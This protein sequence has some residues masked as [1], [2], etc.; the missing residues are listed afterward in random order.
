[1]PALRAGR[2]L[3]RAQAIV[4]HQF[5]QPGERGLVRQPLEGQPRGR[6]GRVAVIGQQVAPAEF[7]RVHTQ[8]AR[9]EIDQPLRHHAGHGVAH[10]AVLAGGR[11]VGEGHA[12]PR[13]IGRHAV[14]GAG[15]VHHLVALDRTGPRIDGIGPDAGEII[16]R[17]C[18]D[19][20]I[21]RDRQLAIDGVFARVN[22]GG[23]GFQPVRHEFHRSAQQL[24]DRHGRHV[25]GID[26]HLDAEGPPHI[27]A[28]DAHAL[29]GQAEMLGENLL[30][31]VRR[32]AGV[33]H[34]QQAGRAVPVG[35]DGARLQRH[36]GVARRREPRL[37]HEMRRGEGGI[38]IAGVHRAREGEVV[39]QV[40]MDGR[41][42][43]RGLRVGHCG[44]RFP[45]GLDQGGGVF[46]L[47]AALRH[48]GGHGLAL[49]DGAAIG[50]RRL[51]R[52]FQALEMRQHA[53]PRRHHRGEVN[54]RQHRHH[55]GHGGSGGD[56]EREARMRVGAAQIGH[57]NQPRQP[58]II[59]IA[60]ATGDQPRRR[61]AR[62]GAADPGIGAIRRAED[63]VRHGGAPARSRATLSMASTMAW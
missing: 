32:L 16:D 58:Q 30:H 45:F 36:A 40:G 18:E 51:R 63:T 19:G 1:M 20:A 13:P 29:L 53:D 15:D 39:P 46:C 4:I 38:H 44:Q 26:M 25:I 62:A 59:H 3:L 54:R 47:G 27:G 2:H 52:R 9:R 7:G 55:A 8:A 60:P 57:V 48:H 34:R 31:H 17:E 10:G 43:E 14:P 12:Q 50:Q 23:E 33:M 37:H 35:Q 28:D 49:P 61:L 56:I 6:L 41:A 24:R 42:V 22:V 5:Q 21:G 11:L